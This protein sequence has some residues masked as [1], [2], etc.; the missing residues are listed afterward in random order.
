MLKN[1]AYIMTAATIIIF[2]KVFSGQVGPPSSARGPEVLWIF[3]LIT[4]VLWI[5]YGLR[6]KGETQPSQV[7]DQNNNL[8]SVEK[9]VVPDSVLDAENKS[10][11]SVTEYYNEALELYNANKKD[12]LM[13]L[14]LQMYL[15]YPRSKESELVRKLFV[16]LNK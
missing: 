8:Q 7:I 10:N 14:G 3:P 1:L 12:E 6:Q 2:I 15:L 16:E 9:N 13:A 5:I 4:I 11:K